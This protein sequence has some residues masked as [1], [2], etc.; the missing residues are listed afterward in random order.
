MVEKPF[1]SLKNQLLLA[2]P[3]LQDPRFSRAVIYLCEHN[4]DGAMGLVINQPIDVPMSRVFEDLAV[5]YPDHIGRR[6]LLSG[7]PVQQERG[8]VLHKSA[9]RH[10]EST[11]EV[12]PDISIT[13]SRDIIIDIARAEG[14]ADSYITLG[15]AGWGPGQLEQEL[16]DNAWLTIPADPDII[17][18]TPFPER[19]R[20]TAARIGVDLDRL[21]PQVGHA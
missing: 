16:A 14:P 19:A 12:S 20:A 6:P 2:M 10:W 17:F 15:Y 8:F 5:E 18:A 13:A 9:D 3:G 7:G 4:E 1:L 11:V 21:S